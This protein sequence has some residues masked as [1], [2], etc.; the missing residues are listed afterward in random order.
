MKT[1]YQLSLSLALAALFAV[2]NFAALGAM[3]LKPGQGLAKRVYNAPVKPNS[4]VKPHSD[5]WNAA[6]LDK[7]GATSFRIDTGS[8]TAEPT[9][10]GMAG[11]HAKAKPILRNSGAAPHSEAWDA[12]YLDRYGNMHLP[13]Y[14]KIDVT[15]FHG[16]G[17][18]TMT[19]HGKDLSRLDLIP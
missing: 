8:E 18:K 1:R 15:A 3:P 7:F 9:R 2:L 4:G 10:G 14:W 12:F 17:A 5:E 6:Y 16:T 13:I 19:K 11:Q